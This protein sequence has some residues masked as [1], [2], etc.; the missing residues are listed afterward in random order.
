MSFII[1]FLI[2]AIF[3][4]ILCSYAFYS[5]LDLKGIQKKI[6]AIKKNNHIQEI[7]N[8]KTMEKILKLKLDAENKCKNIDNETIK[9]LL[10]L[11]NG[12]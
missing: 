3:S 12:K 6:N 10:E 5:K 2:G 8:K 4:F 7:Q 9:K 1:G 11:N